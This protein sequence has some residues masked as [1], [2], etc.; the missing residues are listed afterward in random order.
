M[1]KDAG[2]T[3]IEMVIVIAVIGILA[4]IVIPNFLA[5]REGARI[6]G[7]AGNLRADFEMAKL[8]AIK[9]NAMV[10]MEF[11]AD[12]YRV[13][14]DLND[15]DT[16]DA[17]ERILSNTTFPPGVTMSATTFPG[18]RMEFNSRG[19]PNGNSGT[20]SLVNTSG[21]QIDVIVSTFGRIR[22]E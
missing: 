3:L 18:S 8:R 6:R 21:T 13:Y 16:L 22:T 14:V 9:D 7:A 10:G 20:V 2:F 5:Y 12:S 15:N 17:G 4:A 11:N 19:V 1:K